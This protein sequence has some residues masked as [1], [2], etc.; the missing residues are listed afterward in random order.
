M[1]AGT[2]ELN[3]PG[4]QQVWINVYRESQNYGGNYSTFRVQVVYKGNGYG[5]FANSVDQGWSASAPG[6]SWGGTF[7]ILSPGTGD[8]WLLDTTF[9]V[10]HD[11]NGYLGA[12]NVSAWIDTSHGSIGDGGVTVTEGESPRI[13][14]APV[15]NGQPTV[16]GLLPTQATLTW[17][18]NTNNNGAGIDQY[19]LRVRTSSPA[20]GAGYVDYPVDGSTLSKTITGLTP[21]QNYYAVVYAHNSQG[22]A[23]KSAETTFRTPSGFYVW[24]GS[25]WKPTEIFVWNGTAWRTGE[26]FVWDGTAWKAAT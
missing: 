25:E 2:G 5:S 24:N 18:A 19:L 22:Y 10:G 15:T 26:V 9:N 23:P 12:F 14:K 4:N 21:G 11:G 17:P 16:S 20:D 7:R 8:I 13:P 3:G 1:P 6:A